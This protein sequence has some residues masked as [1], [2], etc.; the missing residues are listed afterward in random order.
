MT[1]KR[2]NWE[3][4]LQY[5]VCTDVGMRR[6]NNQ[7]SHAVILPRN[8]EAWLERGDPLLLM[9][10]DG[11]GAHAAGELASKLAVDGVPHL[12]QKYSY[13][14]PPEAIEKA[15]QEANAEVHRRGQANVDFN[16]MGTTVS[17]L[18]LLP[19]GALIAHI[20]D[21][22]VYRLRKGVLHQ[23]TFDHSLVW[24]MR[25]A[26]Q[27]PKDAE[28]AK[29]I[30]K[31]VITRSLGPYPEVD[32]D[33]EGP[34]PLEIDDAFLLC[35]DGLTAK[36]TDEE[37]ASVLAHMEPTRAVSFLVDLAN[38]R[39]GP[40]NIT[41]M[42]GKVTNDRMVSDSVGH[43]P[44]IVGR[45]VDKPPALPVA[46]MAASVLVLAS[47]LMMIIDQWWVA[48][49]LLVSAIGCGGWAAFAPWF[50]QTTGISLN[51]GRK[52]GKGPYVTVSA[53]SEQQFSQHLAETVRQLRGMARVGGWMDGAREI[54]ECCQ[55]AEQ[56][57]H[58]GDSRGAIRHY[59]QATR[60]LMG[61]LRNF[62]AG[63]SGRMGQGKDK[64]HPQ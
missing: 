55:D 29:S 47:F 18:V 64:A 31:N 6:D 3:G 27:F 5:A 42:I 4:C 38:V 1:A 50:A 13:L 56:A 36:V 45:P 60:D 17:V 12:Y 62:Q 14:S 46:G 54:E 20:G 9:V 59:V 61:R 8:Y 33:I 30:P 16:C 52:L 23:W 26:G 22:R 24:E 7:D 28:L 39:G 34:L 48:G 43:A 35:S 25:A 53:Q 15:L 37:I 41:V 19:Q 57:D 49:A 10:A 32:I 21:S 51:Q 40:D 58:Q 2:G 44:L 63:I 11:M